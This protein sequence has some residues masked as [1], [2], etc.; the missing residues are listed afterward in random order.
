MKNSAVKKPLGK[1][2]V[3]KVPMVMQMEALECG[4]ASLDMVLGYYGRFVP[5]SQLRK[6]CGVSRDG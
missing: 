6:D 1:G 4:A 5:L 3:A 2:Q